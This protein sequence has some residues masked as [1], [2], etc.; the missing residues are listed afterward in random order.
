MEAYDHHL[1]PGKWIRVSSELSSG[2][3]P[4]N[5]TPFSPP[6]SKVF[7]L[8]MIQFS[9]CFRGIVAGNYTYFSKIGSIKWFKK[10]V[11]LQMALSFTWA[12]RTGSSIKFSPCV[13]VAPKCPA[14]IMGKCGYSQ[15]LLWILSPDTIYNRERP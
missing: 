9:F 14:R 6:L 1:S 3:P 7:M 4:T 12:V 8:V 11:L 2:F 10:P 15:L 13:S 5:I